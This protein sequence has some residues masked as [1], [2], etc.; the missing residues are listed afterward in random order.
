MPA[1][2][3]YRLLSCVCFLLLWCLLVARLWSL[4]LRYVAE[5]KWDLKE[6]KWLRERARAR[7]LVMLVPLLR[8]GRG[9][10]GRLC[11][12]GLLRL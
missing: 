7:R 9:L 4:A 6:W 8:K 11:R 3:R 12:L 5:E 1:A 10:G 2:V